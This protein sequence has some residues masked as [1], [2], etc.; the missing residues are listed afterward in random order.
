MCRR[1]PIRVFRDASP[2]TVRKGL[3]PGVGRPQMLAWCSRQ[4]RLIGRGGRIRERIA[5]YTCTVRTQP[6]ANV[7]RSQGTATKN[8]IESHTG[9]VDSIRDAAMR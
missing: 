3:R 5:A 8:S 1:A 6:K 7:M 2:Q 9:D 4:M